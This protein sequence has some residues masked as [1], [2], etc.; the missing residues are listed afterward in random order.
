MASL[1]GERHAK[2]RVHGYPTADVRTQRFFLCAA[3]LL[4]T[5][6]LALLVAWSG[7]WSIVAR[8]SE[9]LTSATFLYRPPAVIEATMIFGG[10]V[11][12][13]VVQGRYTERIPFWTELRL[14]V[15]ASVFG[16]AL[17]GALGVLAGDVL[18]RVPMVGAL[19]LLPAC[20]TAL[21]CWFKKVLSAI[22]AWVLPVVIIG[23]GACAT[24][25]EAALKSDGLLGYR[26]VGR[27]SPLAITAEPGTRELRALMSQYRAQRLI[28]SPDTRGLQQ[29]RVVEAALRERVPFVAMLPSCEFP[30]YVSAST[31]L[32]GHGAM[33]LASQDGLAWRLQRLIKALIDVL[34]AS[35]LLVLASPVFFVIAAAVRLDGGPALFGHCRV[36]E[37]GRAFRCLKFRTMVVDA[38]RILQETLAMDP[39]RAAE[40]AATRKLVDDPRI[41]RVGRFLR[42]SSLDE[43]PQLFNV[44]RMEMSLVGPRPIVES[45]AAL[46]GDGIAQYYATIPGITGLWQVS[47][48]SNTSY[49]QRVQL[50]VW[51]V[52]NWTIW[53][54]MVVLFKTIPVVLGREG[55]R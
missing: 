1:A 43:V 36:G 32:V 45:E 13:L 48:R 14:V 6:V 53:L 42:K 19:V 15:G 3:M 54:D 37:G 35:L 26:I 46:Y 27:I 12:Y 20:A 11:A 33:L 23:E 18:G 39:V 47:G 29:R 9:R 41:T 10:I 16:I 52:N 38:D 55:A 49:A 28:I 51:Y 17:E 5:D 8:G 25:A 40:W 7:A 2:Q 21:N 50:D 31:R 44:L 30:A 4:G 24:A 34:G 22:G